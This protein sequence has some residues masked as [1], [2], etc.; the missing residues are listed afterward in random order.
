MEAVRA[1]RPAL[2][3]LAVVA[4]PDAAAAVVASLALAAVEAAASLLVAVAAVVGAEV[5]VVA[6]AGAE[7]IL[8]ELVVQAGALRTRLPW[9]AASMIGLGEK[10]QA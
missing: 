9:R 5:A 10:A 6:P 8:N 2:K 7:R 4:A 3:D 1:V